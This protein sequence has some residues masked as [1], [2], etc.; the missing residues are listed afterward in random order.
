VE[1]ARGILEN[2]PSLL[3]KGGETSEE[4]AKWDFLANR[5][6][7][8]RRELEATIWNI[9]DHPLNLNGRDL[10]G[11]NLTHLVDLTTAD[12]GR[13]QKVREAFYKLFPPEE[14]PSSETK[15]KVA[16]A[17]LYYGVFWN[18]ISPWYY[19][20]YNLGDWRRTIR[21]KGSEETRDA[22]GT[23]FHR[24]CEEFIREGIS[25]DEFLETKKGSL[26][27]DL[28]SEM[29]LRKAIIWYSEKLGT[30]VLVKGMY[31][32]IEWGEQSDEHFVNLPALWNT[33]GDFRGTHG[34]RRIADL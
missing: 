9:E 20:N 23:V 32:A 33:Q 3:G 34:N 8:E 11:I 27:I 21:G 25:L 2:D 26:P 24:F 5:P 17:L 18:R 1:T 13:L 30:R 19:K 10:G 29:N 22:G 12:L 7:D 6:D 28:D 4:R 14:G 15:K 16:S 31:V